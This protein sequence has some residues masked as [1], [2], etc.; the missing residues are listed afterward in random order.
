MAQGKFERALNFSAGILLAFGCLS[1]V[2]MLLNVSADV[3]GRVFFNR[4][5]NATIELVEN[6]YMVAATFLPLAYVQGAR[7]HVSV[8][9]VI[10]HLPE[11]GRFILDVFAM[12]LTVAFL[13]G[14]V[15]TGADH[16]IEATEGSEIVYATYFDLPVWPTRWFPVIACGAAAL[17]ALLHLIQ[18]L[19]RP[20]TNGTV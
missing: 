4:P 8:D 3:I 10:R 2:A 11:R 12:A 19:R 14:I 9:L 18:R 5:V 6:W 1:A 15:W 7:A 20:V 16:A 13:L 17:F